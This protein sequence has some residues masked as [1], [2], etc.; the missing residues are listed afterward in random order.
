MLLPGQTAVSLAV[1]FGV[2]GGYTVITMVWV[3]VE[4]PLVTVSVTVYVPGVT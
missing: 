2:G 3:Y 4:P 1:K